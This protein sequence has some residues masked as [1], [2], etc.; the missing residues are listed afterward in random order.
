MSDSRVVQGW[1]LMNEKTDM[2]CTE[3]TPVCR[4]KY[5]LHLAE[6]HDS[7]TIAQQE[8]E[9]P[10]FNDDYEHKKCAGQ[11]VV[12]RTPLERQTEYDTLH[13][14]FQARPCLRESLVDCGLCTTEYVGDGHRCVAKCGVSRC[15]RRFYDDSSYFCA[16]HLFKL[17]PSLQIAYYGGNL[18]MRS[19]LS[20]YVHDSIEKRLIIQLLKETRNVTF[21]PYDAP[22]TN[23]TCLWCQLDTL[24]DSSFCPTHYDEFYKAFQSSTNST[25]YDIVYDDVLKI[26]SPG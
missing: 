3:N 7:E 10:V 20:K 21:P 5:R 6:R 19:F 25:T 2:L 26:L 22:R 17:N 12:K 4:N 24:P 8:N 23:K 15:K 9:N 13:N 18:A 1:E 11:C 14:L 16:Y